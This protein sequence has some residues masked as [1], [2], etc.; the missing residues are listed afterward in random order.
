MESDFCICDTEGPE[1]SAGQLSPI[2]L[3]NLHKYEQKHNFTQ[4]N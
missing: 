2:T 3:V 4:R 1:F